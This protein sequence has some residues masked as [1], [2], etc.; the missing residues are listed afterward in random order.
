MCYGDG[1]VKRRVRKVEYPVQLQALFLLAQDFTISIWM[2][3]INTCAYISK[4]TQ[5]QIG[6]G[7]CGYH[8]FFFL[9]LSSVI[10]LSSVV[11][12]IGRLH[13]LRMPGPAPGVGPCRPAAEISRGLVDSWGGAR[14]GRNRRRQRVLRLW[15]C[16]FGSI[17]GGCCGLSSLL[18]RRCGGSGCSCDDGGSGGGHAGGERHA[19]R[20]QKVC[21]LSDVC[22]HRIRIGLEP[23]DERLTRL[24]KRRNLS[25]DGFRRRR[26]DGVDGAAE[27][28]LAA[29]RVAL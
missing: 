3:N 16:G 14:L 23:F 13:R 29:A 22:A 10:G 20:Q 2:T 7:L 26:S 21:T 6:D 4:V 28:R 17:H 11:G 25:G 18:G 15:R 5:I 8:Q 27:S 9:I 24:R 1:L 19:K 12:P